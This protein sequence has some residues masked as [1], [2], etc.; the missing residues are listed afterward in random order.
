MVE[1][2]DARRSFQG[3]GIAGWTFVSK[4]LAAMKR[5]RGSSYGFTDGE[6]NTVATWGTKNST[7]KTEES[8]LVSVK[9]PKLRKPVPLESSISK[10][11]I[12]WLNNQPRCRARKISWQHLG[13]R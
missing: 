10:R 6:V 4:E 9:H 13:F 5:E 11:I 3:T 8:G 12:A 7:N 1:S 2:E